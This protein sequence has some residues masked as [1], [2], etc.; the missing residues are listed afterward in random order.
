MADARQAEKLRKQAEEDL[1]TAQRQ[2]EGYQMEASQLQ[3]VIQDLKTKI[4]IQLER[5]KDRMAKLELYGKAEKDMQRLLGMNQDKDITLDATVK[6]LNIALSDLQSK[7]QENFDLMVR[8]HMATSRH[9]ISE[10]DHP[11]G[12]S[13]STFFRAPVVQAKLT[14]L[15]KENAD[16]HDALREAKRQLALDR[17]RGD[18]LQGELEPLKEQMLKERAAT[19]A[20]LVRNA[21]LEEALRKGQ[22]ALR[23]SQFLVSQLGAPPML[24]AVVPQAID[25]APPHDPRVEVPQVKRSEPPPF[26]AGEGARGRRLHLRGME[27]VD[28]ITGTAQSVVRGGQNEQMAL[29]ADYVAGDNVAL[30]SGLRPTAGGLQGLDAMQIAGLESR[31]STALTPPPGATTSSVLAPTPTPDEHPS[32]DPS[33]PPTADDSEPGFERST[34]APVMGLGLPPR[35]P[36]GLMPAV[37]EHRP[38]AAQDLSRPWTSGDARTSAP[39]GFARPGSSGGEVER[40]GTAASGA[41]KWSQAGLP[42][43]RERR[44]RDVKRHLEELGSVPDEI[45]EIVRPPPK[46]IRNVADLVEVEVDIAMAKFE[47]EAGALA[48]DKVKAVME[49]S[50]LVHLDEAQTQWVMEV[51]GADPSKA[52]DGNQHAAATGNGKVVDEEGY[53]MVRKEEADMVVRELRS[54]I[55]WMR[56]AMGVVADFSK[57]LRKRIASLEKDNLELVLLLDRTKAEMMEL[58]IAQQKRWYKRSQDV[59]EERKREVAAVS[60]QIHELRVAANQVRGSAL[61]AATN[62]EL[63]DRFVAGVVAVEHT[64]TSVEC[65]AGPTGGAEARDFI[66]SLGDRVDSVRKMTVEELLRFVIG[67]LSYRSDV[68]NACGGL[69]SPTE[70]RQLCEL[71]SQTWCLV[72]GARVPSVWFI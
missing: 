32:A 12:E 68:V 11:L 56:A 53:E 62:L 37:P 6:S 35:T 14:A 2:M 64:R 40:P 30:Q 15:Q 26:P 66:K 60:E 46:V 1:L 20:L 3:N 45:L 8:C 33:R 70:V 27:R 17:S 42:M 71:K 4:Q 36:P 38:S 50:V 67:V 16:V 5:D 52:F 54:R 59:L 58:L 49:G 48:R 57:A 43:P 13:C 41:S 28:E 22:R 72:S 51:A 19:A 23:T 47:E 24:D 29:F 7:T 31:P 9:S 44:I 69:Q 65:Q 61:K 34:S 55:F 63:R 21:F 10:V 39:P 25:N 18:Q